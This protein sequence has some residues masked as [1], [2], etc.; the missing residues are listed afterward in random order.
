[1]GC[2]LWCAS[3]V[4]RITDINNYCS[5]LISF[6]FLGHSEDG[7]STA[8]SGKRTRVMW[9]WQPIFLVPCN[10]VQLDLACL[11]LRW[12]FPNW[13]SILISLMVKGVQLNSISSPYIYCVARPD[14]FFEASQLNRYLL[15]IFIF[16]VILLTKDKAEARLNFSVWWPIVG[17]T[18]PS[19][20]ALLVL[21]VQCI[22]LLCSSNTS[23]S[24]Q[25]NSVVQSV[26]NP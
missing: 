21:N 16:L 23:W 7:S 18:L 5:S 22:S 15:K 20:F 9:V 8:Y 19:F 11:S 2:T 25:Y 1:M 13:Q 14:S 17:I 26:S 6:S 12:R 4:G 3:L 24:F 10:W